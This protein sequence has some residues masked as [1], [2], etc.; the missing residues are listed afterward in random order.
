MRP[1]LLQKSRVQRLSEFKPALGG[2]SIQAYKADAGR[3]SRKPRDSCLCS[4]P[5]SEYLSMVQR[6][7]LPGCKVPEPIRS[8]AAGGTEA[9]AFDHRPI[10]LRSDAPLRTEESKT[11]SRTPR[12]AS[13]PPK[14]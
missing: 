10:W 9:Y 1:A 13:G 2:E 5:D 11:C 4:S 7:T 12:Q 3:P 6:L 14:C 8:L